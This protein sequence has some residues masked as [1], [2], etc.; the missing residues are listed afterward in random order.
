MG[1]TFDLTSGV[2][3]RGQHHRASPGRCQACSLLALQSTPALA[4]VAC[5]NPQRENCISVVSQA[6]W[7]DASQ[8]SNTCPKNLWTRCFPKLIFELLVQV[9]KVCS[10]FWD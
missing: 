6:K 8:S 5:G 2:A 7:I 9:K 4:Q 1:N 10:R 3:E